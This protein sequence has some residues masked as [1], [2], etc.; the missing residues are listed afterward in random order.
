MVSVAHFNIT[1]G[2]DIPIQGSPEG[3]VRSLTASGSPTLAQPLLAALDCTPFEEVKFKVLVTVGQKVK[4][5][6]PLAEDK[7]HP[8]RYFVSPAGGVVR[9][10]R[11][12]LKRRLLAIIVEIMGKEELF[13]LTPPSPQT[14]SREE[15]VEFLKTSGLFSLIR[16]RPFNFLADPSQRPRSIFIKAIESAPFVPAAEMHVEGLGKEFQAGLNLLARL[17]EGKV[18]LVYRSSSTSS[19]F[20]NATGVEHH[21][22]EGPHPAGNA[23]VHIERIDP[24][25]SPDH[26]LWT[27]DSRSVVAIG[28]ALLHRHYRIERIVSIAGP[29]ILEESRGFFKI[30]EGY[31]ISTLLTGRIGKDPVRLIS[32]NPLTGRQVGDEDFLGFYDT[33]FVAIPR[34]SSAREFLHFFRLGTDKYTF[35]GTYLSALLPQKHPYAFTTHQHGEERPF[36]DNT[37]YDRVMPLNI[38]TMHLVKAILAEDEDLAVEL[39]LLEVDSEDFALPAFVCPSKID[40]VDIVRTGLRRA[41]RSL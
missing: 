37:L 34:E 9:E 13:S 40:M 39:G 32:G 7:E 1:K 18:H 14:A 28:Y 33:S 6:E 20:R 21:T 12:G 41:A 15:I 11:R 26:L 10:I 22:I 19:V 3:A 30:R 35:S 8:G 31:P 36:I 2:L 25:R 23:S 24:I 27:L 38:S 29:G 4:I 16:Q 5:G 17:T